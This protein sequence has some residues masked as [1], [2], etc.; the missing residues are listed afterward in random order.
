MQPEIHLEGKMKLLRKNVLM[1]VGVLSVSASL[2]GVANAASFSPR[3]AGMTAS[4]VAGCPNI[5]WRI[6]RGA[7]GSLNGIMWFDDMSGLSHATGSESGGAFN[8]TLTSVMGSGP[9]GTVTGHIGKGATL[10]G[11]GCANATFKPA[12]ITHYSS[13]G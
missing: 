7:D 4:S 11:E 3:Y 2:A 5:V 9:V 8:M 10:K 13:V 12:V 1:A 6:G